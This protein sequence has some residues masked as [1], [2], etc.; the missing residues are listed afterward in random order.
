[1]DVDAK[2]HEVHGQKKEGAAKSYNGIYSL[3]PLYGFVHETD[4]LIQAELR[5]GNT[6]PGAKGVAFLRRME[7]KIP[8][9]INSLYLLR[10]FALFNK[11]VVMFCEKRGWTFSITADQYA[12]L[13]RQIEGLSEPDRQPDLED[14]EKVYSEVWYQPVKRPR[15]TVFWFVGRR[16]RISPANVF[17][18][19][20]IRIM[21]W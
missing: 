9:E 17:C 4:E 8:K 5:S 21:W 7:K 6:H 11:D 13:M 14:P 10:E 15:L 20:P 16:K 18:L 19:R 2:V 12:P 3:Q 1:M